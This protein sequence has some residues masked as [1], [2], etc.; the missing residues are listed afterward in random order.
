M[1]SSC[2]YNIFQCG[3]N[4]YEVV[5][6]VSLTRLLS[7]SFLLPFKWNVIKII[8][9]YAQHIYIINVCGIDRRVAE[10]DS[11]LMCGSYLTRWLSFGRSRAHTKYT[12]F[13]IVRCRRQ[14]PDEIVTQ[15]SLRAFDS[16]F[17]LIFRSLDTYE[18]IH[19]RT[20]KHIQH[21]KAR[22]KL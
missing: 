20:D 5:S 9:L 17:R 10:C 12:Q 7:L 13:F 15:C 22:S 8:T 3:V 18:Y 6:F 21:N 1:N 2:A 19:K 16:R 4:S 11:R 14:S